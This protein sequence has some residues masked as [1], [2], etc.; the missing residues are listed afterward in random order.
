MMFAT[1]M[2]GRV[3]LES[4]DYQIVHFTELLNN[5]QYHSV[6]DTIPFPKHFYDAVCWK[7]GKKPVGSVPSFM[8]VHILLIKP[9]VVI[10]SKQ[11]GMHIKALKLYHK[12]LI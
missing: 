8:N 3:L 12:N 1:K 4:F 2:N 6:N 7:W 10:L 11:A 5:N 9:C